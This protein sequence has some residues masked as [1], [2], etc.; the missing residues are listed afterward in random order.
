[1]Q[2][3]LERKWNPKSLQIESA[4]APSSAWKSRYSRKNC[5]GKCALPDF[6][7]LGR[8]VY[9]SRCERLTKRVR[10]DF[11][12]A[13]V[14]GVERVDVWKK[15]D[16]QGSLRWLRKG[17]RSTIQARW[18]QTCILP[19]VLLEESTT[20]KKSILDKP[21]VLI[22]DWFSNI[23]LLFFLFKSFGSYRTR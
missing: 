5:L 10:S 9:K 22:W 2:P 15:R 13:T 4:R 21:I 12:T 19:R 8:A 20:T 11:C 14:K 3:Y 17:M 6:M 23:F 7:V 1:M 18:Q 16:A